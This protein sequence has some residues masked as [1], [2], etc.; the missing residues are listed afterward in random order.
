MLSNC[1]VPF[2]NAEMPISTQCPKCQKLYKLKDELLGKRVSCASASCRTLFEVKPYVPPGSKQHPKLDAEAV[3]AAALKDE[4]DPVEAVPEDMR[5]IAMA[6]GVCEF[7]FEV[8]WGLQGKNTICPE[9]KHRQKVPEQKAANQKVD[10]K[11]INSKR[12]TLA[13]E[14][15]VPDD[16]WGAKKANV[17]VGAMKEAGA[18]K[19]VEYEPRPLSFW[20]KIGTLA[21]VVLAVGIGGIVYMSKSK[22]EQSQLELIKDAKGDFDSFKDAGIPPAAAPQFKALNS[23][24]LA[25]YHARLDTANDLKLATQHLGSARQAMIGDARGGDRE[26]ILAELMSVTLAFGGDAEQVKGGG[27]LPWVPIENVK[28]SGL[29]QNDTTVVN[30]LKK[31]FEDLQQFADFDFR[32][33]VLR[34]LTRELEAKG[35]GALIAGLVNDG[36]RSEEQTEASAMV[37]LELARIA[38]NTAKATEDAEQFKPGESAPGESFPPTVHALWVLTNATGV[39]KAPAAASGSPSMASRMTSLWV[40]LAQNQPA[41]ALTIAKMPGNGDERLKAIALVAELLPAEAVPAAL[42]VLASRPTVPPSVLARLAKAAGTIGNDDAVE[43]FVAAIADDGW[44][45]WARG[46]ALRAKIAASPT[47]RADEG[48]VP[49]IDDGKKLRAGHA[50]SKLVLFRHN[51]K[52]G[53]NVTPE[54][55]ALPAGSLRPFGYLGIVLGTM[56][57]AA[58]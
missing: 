32:L 46:D 36:F 53:L 27:K 24:A 38:N 28:R 52:L 14:P 9:C 25:E 35:Q 6:C 30:E 54:A 50:W 34:R 16:V 13:K 43:K 41:E 39:P 7:K 23:L 29:K 51:A 40:K 3:A 45:A 48:S 19:G 57:K 49:P 37:S 26:A 2:D 18:I 44:K 58:K 33:A 42:E 21:A 22:Q 31:L 5:K 11:N 56:D 20:V 55:K 17:S 12:P 1:E 47:A 8:A 10:W 4:P 15:E